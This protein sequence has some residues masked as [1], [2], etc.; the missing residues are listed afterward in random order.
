MTD[1]DTPP[2]PDAPSGRSTDSLPGGAGTAGSTSEDGGSSDPLEG[3]PVVKE[4]EK[5]EGI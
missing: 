4:G 1:A 2:E 5:G 3:D